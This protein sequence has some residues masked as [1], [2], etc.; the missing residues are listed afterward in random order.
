MGC[1]DGGKYRAQTSYAR[2]TSVA[3]VWEDWEEFII[4]VLCEATVGIGIV[5]VN[6]QV[7]RWG[8]TII[9]L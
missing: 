2:G 4:S 5:C 8:F 7:E 3:K 6:V 9:W 1:D